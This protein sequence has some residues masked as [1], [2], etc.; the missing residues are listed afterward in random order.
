MARSATSA[1][2]ACGRS[3]VASAEF[4]ARSR[5]WTTASA[6]GTLRSSSIA[7]VKSSGSSVS[8]T[9]RSSTAPTCST[10]R[11]TKPASRSQAASASTRVSSVHSSMER[12]WTAVMAYRSTAGLVVRSTSVTS[13]PLPS[14]LLIFAPDWVT[15][16]LCSQNRAKGYPA[17]RDW[18]CS[19]SWCG[20][21]RSRPPP[22][23]SN[24]SPR[25]RWAIAEHSRCQPGRP[26]PNGVDQEA[27]AGSVGLAAFHSAKSRGSCLDSSPAGA[28]SG[29][30][31]MSSSRWL[32]SE[33]YS[34]NDRTSK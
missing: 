10:A 25:Y 24:S 17:A 3:P 15:Q 5:S 34:G 30:G 13:S 2:R 7:A 32:V 8:R 11:S 9:S 22:W 33:P 21:R 14:D 28:P 31:T 18:A 26:R 20:K 4:P 19:F 6:A 12:Y 1:A 27:V 29:A 16:P 23:M